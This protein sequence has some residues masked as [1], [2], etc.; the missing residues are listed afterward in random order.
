M[1]NRHLVVISVDAMVCED[2]EFLKEQ[3][4]FKR[5]LANGSYIKHVRTVYPSLTHVVHTSIITGCTPARTGVVS[6]EHFCPGQEHSP[7]YNDLDE[8]KCDTLFHAVKRAGKTSCACRW[9]VTC[10]GQNIIDYLVPEIMDDDLAEEPDLLKLHKNLCSHAI[11]EDI[12]K[13]NI[14]IL[15]WRHSKHPTDEL[16]QVKCVCDIIKKYKP[17]FIVT[18]PCLLDASRHQYGLFQNKLKYAMTMTDQLLGEILDAID[19]AGISNNT[20]IVIVSDHGHIET[21]RSISINHF[22]EEGMLR[23]NEDGSLKNWDVYAKGCGLSCEIYV[24]DPKNN[25]KVE[26]MLHK[27][28]QEG[29]Y[30]FSD[31]MTAAEAE[32]KY[33]LK[34]EFSFIVDTDGYTSFRDDLTGPA[35]KLLKNEDYRYGHSDHGH[36]PEKGPQP[37]MI[38]Y[39][40]DFKKGIVLEQGNII[41]EA[42]TFAKILD[43]SL[44]D[45]QG[46]PLEELLLNCT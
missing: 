31:V 38:V 18:H 40:P 12:I 21:V 36:M 39:G 26:T 41:D 15:N 27:M 19:D 2:L 30:G 5:V 34:G 32:Q 8:I 4:N 33:G 43:I 3:P 9:P 11:Y 13:P 20:D 17:D 25:G 1:M 37:S 24:R 22:L 7:W 35:V 45:A 46:S 16:F 29:I 28:K 6:N 23:L 14:S 10:G 44:K 42:P